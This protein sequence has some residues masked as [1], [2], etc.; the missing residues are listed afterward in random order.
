M[1]WSIIVSPLVSILQFMMQPTPN[2]VYV[3]VERLLLIE[4]SSHLHFIAPNIDARGGY[5]SVPQRRLDQQNVPGPSVEPDCEGVPKRVR[6]HDPLDSRS[7]A[8][9]P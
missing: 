4:D 6:R 9:E 3:N 5:R 1:L 7:L 8:P 2:V